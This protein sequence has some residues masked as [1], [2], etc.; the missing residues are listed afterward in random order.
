VLIRTGL[1]SESATL[2]LEIVKVCDAGIAEPARRAE[3]AVE[4]SRLCA[5]NTV[6]E[7]ELAGVLRGIDKTIAELQ[8]AL[9]SGAYGW[10]VLAQ[11]Y[12]L[13]VLASQ[14]S[15]LLSG[16]E[17]PNQQMRDG[18]AELAKGSPAVL[19]AAKYSGVSSVSFAWSRPVTPEVRDAVLETITRVS[20][21]HQRLAGEL[22]PLCATLISLPVFEEPPAP[23]TETHPEWNE[24]LGAEITVSDRMLEMSGKRKEDL[25]P[26]DLDILARA[27][28]GNNSY[29]KEIKN[30]ADRIAV[31]STL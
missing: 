24:P 23:P 30:P 2:S 31:G 15:A 21:T 20:E 19:D 9:M 4:L 3:L 22:L 13:H 27:E 26:A 5:R 17:T 6:L 16:V 29:L 7:H 11:R 12:Q 18:A 25:T 8:K 1:A 28:A 14:I 10:S